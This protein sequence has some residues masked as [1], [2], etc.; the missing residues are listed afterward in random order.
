[1]TFDGGLLGAHL[2]PLRARR[3]EVWR[4]MLSAIHDEEPAYTRFDTPDEEAE[5]GESVLRLFDLFLQLAEGGRRQL[6]PIETEAIRATGATRADQGFGYPAVRASVR[7][8]VGV[9]RRFIV[10]EY[11]PVEPE[12]RAA[13]RRVLE[14]LEWYGNEVEDLLHEGLAARNKH[15]ATHGRTELT[16]LIGDVEAGVIVEDADFARRV[17][18]LGCEAVLARGMVLFPDTKSG[19]AAASAVRTQLP[20][21]VVVHR[22]EAVTPHVLL[23]VEVALPDHW[24]MAIETG[25]VAAAQAGTTAVAIQPCCTVAEYHDRYCAA[26]ALVPYLGRL[27][28]GRAVVDAT[29][30]IPFSVVA[31]M[32]LKARRWL[33]REVLRG[34]DDDRKLLTFLHLSITCGFVLNEVERQSGWDIK[35]VRGY[36]TQLEKTTGRKYAEVSDQAVLALAGCVTILDA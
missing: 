15:R 14:F 23:L 13:L 4:E 9:A 16:N 2:V 1:M 10:D 35:T 26:V 11:A 29:T 3:E 25:Q 30:L 17:S 31:S 21:A 36:R 28:E 33:R 6:T 34:L 32:P 7:A 5:H 24:P 22:P 18:A 27:A 12:D 19:A 8:A 20:G